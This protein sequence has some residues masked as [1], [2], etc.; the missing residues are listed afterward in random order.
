VATGAF[1]CGIILRR[2]APFLSY[3]AKSARSSIWTKSNTPEPYHL[4]QHL[5]L[6]CALITLG[7]THTKRT[8]HLCFQ[9]CVEVQIVRLRG[10]GAHALYIMLSSLLLEQRRPISTFSSIQLE[11]FSQHASENDGTSAGALVPVNSTQ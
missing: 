2:T 11:E 8:E 6:Q 4:L 9:K 1:Q 7:K 5:D 10:V 3:S